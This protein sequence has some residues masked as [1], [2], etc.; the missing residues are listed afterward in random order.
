MPS[1]CLTPTPRWR[2]CARPSSSASPRWWP[3]PVHPRP[4]GDGVRGGVRRL[5]RRPPR[6]SASP[7]A[8]TRS[9]S[10]CARW[11]CSP[12]DD[13]VV[14][15]FTFYA[16]AEAIV[17]AGARPV[18]CDVDP[19]TRNVTVDTVRAALTP[20]TTAIVAVDLFG[21]PAIPDLERA[22][23]A[24]A[25]GRRAGGRRPPRRRG[26][27]GRSATSPPSPSTRP[28][29]SAPSATAAR[30]STDDDERRRRSRGRC[31]STARATR[32]PS[33]TSATTRASTRS[34]RRSCACCCPQLDSWCDGRRA[35]AAAYLAAGVGEHVALPA[36]PGGHRPG[37][38][39]VRV[40][41]PDADELVA[42]LTA[43]GVEARGYYRVPLHRQPAMAPYVGRAGSSCRSPRSWR[44]SNIALPISPVLTDEQAR[45]VVAAL[46]TA[47]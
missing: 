29:T 5:S 15:S 38:A 27:P 43:A 39:S 45:E 2:R 25:R 37:L 34:R 16:T 41:H 18:F 9:R 44:R 21:L 17:N 42:A 8:P 32:R 33:S 11:A 35:A 24:G 36:V 19:D 47:A 40:T 46:A 20:R 23:A 1:P 22:R 10:P 7:T 12:G 30:S 4:G 6:R 28:R 26:W 31:A 3:R 13:V 14:P